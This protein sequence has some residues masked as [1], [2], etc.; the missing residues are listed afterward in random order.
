MDANA[1]NDLVSVVIGVG[2][3]LVIIW[4]VAAY[5]CGTILDVPGTATTSTTFP[6]PVEPPPPPE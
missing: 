3:G 6:E 1:R 5:G 4:I 2:L